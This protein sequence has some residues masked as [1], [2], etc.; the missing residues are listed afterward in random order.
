MTLSDAF[1]LRGRWWSPAMSD[2]RISGTLSYDPVAEM[3]LELDG[4]LEQ[5]TDKKYPVIYG[6]TLDGNACTLV[7]VHVT[8]IHYN[9]PGEINSEA[10]FNQM[11]IGHKHVD[12]ASCLYESAIISLTDLGGWMNR[13]PFSFQDNSD[14]ANGMKKSIT[15]IM[16][17]PILSEVD[18]IDASISIVPSFNLDVEYHNRI[19]HHSEA[20]KITPHKPQKSEWYLQVV[21]KFR[22]LL[23]LLVGRPVSLLR[24]K[25][26]TETKI[27]PEFENKAIPKYI[28]VYMRQT[29][30]KTEKNLLPHQIPFTFSIIEP[31]WSD[32]LKTWFSKV[33]SLDTLSGLFFGVSI[34][35]SLP[36]EFQFLAMIQAIESYHRNL[37]DNLYMSD[38]DYEPIKKKLIEA[39]PSGIGADHQDA[40]RSR[41]KYG[42][43]YSLRKRLDLIFS[44]IDPLI[45]SLIT[46]NKKE[47]ISRVIDTR[48]YLTHRDESQ[49]DNV[50]DFKEMFN[51]SV[52]LKLI[53]E[54]LLLYEVG[55]PVDLIAKVMTS[56]WHYSNRPHIL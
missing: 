27:I 46:G 38:V 5:N 24:I 54:F 21:F 50:L 25:L 22:I 32:I 33:N 45:V 36:V 56:H 42:N 14:Q 48:N 18:C 44:Y 53:V 4:T 34:N 49:K 43:E 17:P 11:F 20:I 52:N 55:V 6:E 1:T 51:A 30:K 9:I 15:Y 10:I 47:F 29:G 2:V 41:I 7:D 39:I 37:S 8:G 35:D 13:D 26:C 16:P 28:D 19:L 31:C 23:T 40:I 12:P 3:R